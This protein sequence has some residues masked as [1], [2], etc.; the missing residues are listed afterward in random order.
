MCRRNSKRW[1]K[2][3]FSFV[4]VVVVD[5][6]YIELF[7]ALEQT[8]CAL[9]ACDSKCGRFVQYNCAYTEAMSSGFF[10]VLWIFFVFFFLNAISVL[11]TRHW[12][13]MS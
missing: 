5:R 6:F 7:S 2:L 8:D 4:V 9:V 11:T 12:M 3:A 10:L 13:P 1:R